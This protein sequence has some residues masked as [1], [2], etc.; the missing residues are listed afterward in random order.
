MFK[1]NRLNHSFIVRALTHSIHDLIP[2]NK[3]NKEDKHR[4]HH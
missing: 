4:D 2:H 1:K 3:V